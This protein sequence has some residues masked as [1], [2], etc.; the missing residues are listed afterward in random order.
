MLIHVPESNMRLKS[1]V[2]AWHCT[3]SSQFVRRPPD[4]HPNTQLRRCRSIQLPNGDRVNVR[5][6]ILIHPDFLDTTSRKLAVGDVLEL[7]FWKSKSSSKV[8]ALVQLYDTGE[9]VPPY[10]YPRLTTNETLG[11]EFMDAEV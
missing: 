6:F 5:D 1:G 7:L 3:T 2:A 11:V 9:C 4:L 8:L 10:R